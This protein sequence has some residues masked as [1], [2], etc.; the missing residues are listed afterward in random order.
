[1][2]GGTTPTALVVGSLVVSAGGI[3]PAGLVVIAYLVAVVCGVVA[4]VVAGIF[5]ALTGRTYAEALVAVTAFG[6]VLVLFLVVATLT[7]FAIAS[8][9]GT[10]LAVFGIPYGVA[11]GVVWARYRLPFPPVHLSAFVGWLLSV[12]A[13]VVTTVVTPL[14]LPDV[15]A[16]ESA[17]IST[18]AVGLLA[19]GIGL[20][21]AEYRPSVLD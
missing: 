11:A 20:A 19:A 8:A 21:V 15:S 10:V 3:T 18:A 4:L 5:T 1:M 16:A 6:C 12:I 2:F 14:S 17:L 13:L 7:P 9:L